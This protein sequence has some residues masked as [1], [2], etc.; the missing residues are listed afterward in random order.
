MQVTETSSEGLRHELKVVVPASEIA[1]RVSGRLSKLQQSARL[2]GFRPGKIPLDLLRK[3]FGSQVMG[4]ALEEAVGETSSKVMEERGLRPALRPQIRITSY[5]ENADLEYEMAVEVMPEIE[6]GDFANLEL[7]RPTVEVTDDQVEEALNRL[8]ERNRRYKTAPSDHASVDGD[9]VVIDFAGTLDGESFAGGTGKDQAVQVGAGQLLPDLDRA[10]AGRKSGDAFS[11]DVAFPDDYPAEALRG[12]TATFAVTVKDVR[13]REE[14]VVDDA[15]A[16]S[17]G[18]ADLASL[19]DDIRKHLTE[20]YARVSR[21]RVKRALLDRLAERFSFA[22][23]A[24]MVESEF[25]AIWRQVEAERGQQHHA[26]D[27]DHAHAHHGHDHDHEHDHGHDHDPE[28]DH[29][30]GAEHGEAAEDDAE[31]SKLKVEYRE[32]AERRVRLGLLLAEVGR[33]NGVDVTPEELNRAIV[34]RARAFPGQERKVFDYYTKNPGA[35]QELRAP[36]FE[37]KVV[38]LI[39]GQAKVVDR[40]VTVEDLMRD[41]DDDSGTT[42]AN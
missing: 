27:H 10:L 13:E 17:F 11:V 14:V 26:H 18:L 20:D 42:S 21:S 5:A 3:R 30:H 15:F 16:K 25:A 37:D 23:P 38:D 9:Q 4:E 32:I 2:P 1:H 36:L 33:R 24:G 19:R 29:P 34:G 39:L 40:V 28:H 35:I 8:V 22:V 31:T 7:T 41:P 12:R 6:P